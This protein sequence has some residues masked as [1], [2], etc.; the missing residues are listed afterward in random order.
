MQDNWI[1]ILDLAK[2]NL[3]ADLKAWASRAWAKA[4]WKNFSQAHGEKCNMDKTEMWL[5]VRSEVFNN[6][7][8]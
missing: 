8:Y 2:E 3:A 5:V 4:Q 6:K 7:E 1:A